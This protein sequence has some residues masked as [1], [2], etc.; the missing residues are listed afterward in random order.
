MVVN[1]VG[2]VFVVDKFTCII[3]S[4]LIKTCY[5]IVGASDED[6]FTSSR[7]NIDNIR[8]K[9]KTIVIS[10]PFRFFIHASP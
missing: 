9:K 1:K 4:T 5:P 10:L 8:G 7:I 6:I 2:T 3:E